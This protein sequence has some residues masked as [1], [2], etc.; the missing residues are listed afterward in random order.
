[1]KRGLSDST[2]LARQPYEDK[3][4]RRWEQT[5]GRSKRSE[6]G[7]TRYVVR[8]GKLIEVKVNNGRR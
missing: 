8:D 5:F 3:D 1:M 4:P 2:T 7:I 6:K